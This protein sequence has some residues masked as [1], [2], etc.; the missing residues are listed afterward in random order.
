MCGRYTLTRRDKLELA[1]ELGVPPEQ[2]GDYH[3]RFNIAPLQRAPIVRRHEGARQALEARWGLVNRWAKDDSQ[4]SKCINA[5]A[6][7]V[8]QR[9]AFRDA[10]VK[11]RCLVPADGFYE[12]TGPPGRRQPLWFH[13]RDGR[14]LYFAGLYEAWQAKPGEWQDTYTILT[15]AANKFM[16]PIHNRMPVILVGD[17]VEEWINPDNRDPAALKPLLLPAPE[18]L[19]ALKPASTRVNSAKYDGPDLLETAR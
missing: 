14:L 2:L 8:E 11:R 19:L 10:F 5:R 18:D 6:E 3:P 4:A 16:E 9:P 13:R 17:A 15:C 7:T 1:A 12:W